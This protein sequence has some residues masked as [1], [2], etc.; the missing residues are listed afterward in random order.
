MEGE[1]VT[2]HYSRV[3]LQPLIVP[4]SL[5]GLLA[6]V[7]VPVLEAHRHFF[8]PKVVDSELGEAVVRPELVAAATGSELAVAVAGFERAT[9]VVESM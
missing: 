4:G 5:V 8:H 9:G 1:D 6:E 3:S 2:P 7:V